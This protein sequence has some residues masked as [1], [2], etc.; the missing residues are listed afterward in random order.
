MNKRIFI[1]IQYNG[2]VPAVVA[3]REELDTYLLKHYKEYKLLPYDKLTHKG[4]PIDCDGV[5]EGH[6]VE[7]Y[8]K[9]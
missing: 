1:V 8:V 9:L 7:R 4:F 5:I 3:S 6:V 2:Y